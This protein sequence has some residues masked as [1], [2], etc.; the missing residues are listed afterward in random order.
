[1]L[2]LLFVVWVKGRYLCWFLFNIFNNIEAERKR[3]QN[4]DVLTA[5]RWACKVMQL[6][7][8][9]VTQN[10]LTYCFKLAGN[11][12]SA[13][14]ALNER[15]V[16]KGM[17]RNTQEHIILHTRAGLRKFSEFEKQSRCGKEGVY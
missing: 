2:E 3:I 15:D 11:D 9:N 13:T 12:C 8:S 17:K 1:M 4:V 7:P 6:S 10:C 14:S 16:F 5:I